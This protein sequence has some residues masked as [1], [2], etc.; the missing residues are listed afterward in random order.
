MWNCWES[1][2][3]QADSLYVFYLRDITPFAGD[4]LAASSTDES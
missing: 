4:F 3:F 2:R 1:Q